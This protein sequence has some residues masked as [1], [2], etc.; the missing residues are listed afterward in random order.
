MTRRRGGDDGAIGG[1]YAGTEPYLARSSREPKAY[2][3]FGD[4]QEEPRHAAYLNG[5]NAPLLKARC[6][7]RACA[8]LSPF[9]E[10]EAA[11]DSLAAHFAHTHP[12]MYGEEERW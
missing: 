7:V 9:T 6:P 4:V 1:R 2:N 11:V 8:W 12:G 3:A 10:R 5:D